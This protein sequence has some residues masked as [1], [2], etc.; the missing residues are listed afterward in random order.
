MHQALRTD[1]CAFQPKNLSIHDLR[2]DRPFA[3]RRATTIRP[4]RSPEIRRIMIERRRASHQSATR[5]M[6]RLVRNAL[7]LAILL[8]AFGCAESDELV[9][10]RS[11][12]AEGRIAETLEPLTNLVESGDRRPEVLYL[13]AQALLAVGENGRALWALDAVIGESE[14]T[15]PA[16][17]ALAFL[18]VSSG[19]H[20][21]AL[22]T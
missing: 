2:S 21:Q 11:I 13:Y 18:E 4:R 15:V 6:G 20:D 7:V 17:R 19:N 14:Y 8:S 5:R 22:Q 1:P 16:A 9:R 3:S 12:Q 10:V